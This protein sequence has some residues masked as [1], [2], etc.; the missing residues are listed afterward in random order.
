M[1]VIE[2]L[3]A[4]LAN[5]RT[6]PPMFSEERA[7]TERLKAK[8]KKLKKEKAQSAADHKKLSKSEKLKR[9][10]KRAGKQKEDGPVNYTLTEEEKKA[11][12]DMASKAQEPSTFAQAFRQARAEQG[13]GGKFT[14][15]GKSYSTNTKDDLKRVSKS[16]KVSPDP[17]KVPKEKSIISEGDDYAAFDVPEMTKRLK[18]FKK[19]KSAKMADTNKS[20]KDSAF[21]I[22]KFFGGD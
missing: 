16:K 13:A 7:E 21:D 6:N 5:R 10:K 22:S 2:E 9:A 1:A 3:E 19:G 8:L 11:G 20:I 12:A 17:V 18:D 14:W 15:N 4:K